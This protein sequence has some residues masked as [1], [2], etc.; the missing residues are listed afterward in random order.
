MAGAKT[1]FENRRIQKRQ[2]V[3]VFYFHFFSVYIGWSSVVLLYG[4]GIESR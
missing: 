4:P 1:V 3:I 2:T